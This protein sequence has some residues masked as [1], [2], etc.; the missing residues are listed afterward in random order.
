M[1]KVKSRYSEWGY[2][3]G[4]LLGIHESYRYRVLFGDGIILF[5]KHELEVAN[6]GR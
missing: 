1:V 2:G 3:V 4:I 5:Y 6:E